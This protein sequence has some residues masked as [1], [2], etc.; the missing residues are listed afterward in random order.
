MDIPSDKTI[1]GL[2]RK[3]APSERAFKTVYEHCQIIAQIAQQII[4][5]NSLSLDEDFVHAA[6]LLHDIGYY[7][8][9]DDSGFVPKARGVE[10]GIAGSAI[11]RKEGLPEAMCRIAECHTGV[12]LTKQEIISQHLPLPHRDFVA[13]TPEEWLVMYADKFHTKAVFKDEP[14]DT[15]GWFNSAESHLEYRRRFGGDNASRFLKLI[16]EY[17]VPSLEKLAKQHKEPIK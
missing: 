7:S 11:L 16:D 9:Y 1:L 3:Y 4:K 12:G 5:T 8:L 17:G 2:H 13:K 14:H 6:A 10:H 15:P